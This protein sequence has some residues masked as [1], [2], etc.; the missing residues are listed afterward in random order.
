MG[1]Y[2]TNSMFQRELRFVIHLCVIHAAL[3]INGKS[4]IIYICKCLGSQVLAC[5]V[6]TR[7]REATE[8]KLDAAVLK[9]NAF[10]EDLPKAA[11]KTGSEVLRLLEQCQIDIGDSAYATASS[12]CNSQAPDG[13][14]AQETFS[15]N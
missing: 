9:G 4:S 13:T 3:W 15:R 12:T 8:A 7:T 11:G 10:L 6:S 14:Q 2:S 5:F 1:H